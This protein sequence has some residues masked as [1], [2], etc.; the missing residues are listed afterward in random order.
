M[1][2]EPQ[3]CERLTKQPL[4]SNSFNI[5]QF[6]TGCTGL[7]YFLHKDRV[8]GVESGLCSCRNGLETPKHVLI[9]CQ[10]EKPRREE[11]KGIGGGRLDLKT[12]QRELEELV[13]GYYVQGAR[14]NSP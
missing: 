4:T 8:P 12:L 13:G 3:M 2:S 9:H 14:P 10:K 6:Q 11:L 5:F 1:N 7:A